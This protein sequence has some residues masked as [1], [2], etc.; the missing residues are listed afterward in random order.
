MENNSA[1]RKP[2]EA[3][4]LREYGRLAEITGNGNGWAWGHYKDHHNYHHHHGLG[5]DE[6]DPYLRAS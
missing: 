3:P 4:T 1:E 2:F 5:P 6:D